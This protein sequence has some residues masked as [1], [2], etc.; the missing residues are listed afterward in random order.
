MPK[1]RLEMRRKDGKRVAILLKDG[2]N[3]IVQF[4]TAAM[5]DDA[6]RWASRGLAELVQGSPRHT[7]P[8]DSDFLPRLA[9]YAQAHGLTASI[10]EVREF[11]T[12]FTDYRA[13][14]VV[15]GVA[16]TAATRAAAGDRLFASFER[17]ARA[18]DDFVLATL[19]LPAAS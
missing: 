10:T 16:S 11:E 8:T 1:A 19:R 17:A 15:A 9:A 3:V 2:D 7:L 5:K 18:N 14:A 4:A 12:L 6:H 13:E